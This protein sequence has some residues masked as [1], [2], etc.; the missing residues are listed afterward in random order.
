M[1]KNRIHNYNTFKKVLEN[2]DPNQIRMDQLKTQI[3]NLQ[4]ELLRLEQEQ[5]TKQ[6]QALQQ[7]GAQPLQMDIAPTNE[8]FDTDNDGT[9]Q[10]GDNEELNHYIRTMGADMKQLPEHQM[11]FDFQDGI[12]WISTS[13]NVNDD[14]EV[15]EEEFESYIEDWAASNYDKE[16]L[17][18]FHVPSG[19]EGFSGRGLDPR[20]F[21]SRI[22]KETQNEIVID[23]IK[24]H[25]RK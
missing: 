21:W 9:V 14:I 19:N 13:A 15:P 11:D 1:S 5:N 24:S 22:D 16:T 18:T 4:K 7:P 2:Q 20:N 3:A 17:R 6:Q 23:F 25:G 12:F 8:G 10:N